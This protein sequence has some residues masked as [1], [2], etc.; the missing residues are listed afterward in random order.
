VR[1]AAAAA[2]TDV[3]VAPAPDHPN[4]D[5]A[6]CLQPTGGGDDDNGGGGRGAI[7]GSSSAGLSPMLAP[8]SPSM[9]VAPRPAPPGTAN[10]QFSCDV[11]NISP[12]LGHRWH[13]TQCVDFDLCHGC[14]VAATPYMFLPPHSPAHPMVPFQCG[15]VPS[16]LHGLR[17]GTRNAH[18]A[19]TTPVS[20]SDATSAATAASARAT[21][22]QTM[23]AS[24]WA[25]DASSTP[26]AQSAAAAV[27]AAV[28]PSAGRRRLAARLAA[29]DD[30]TLG[31]SP[32]H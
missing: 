14:Y 1:H 9:S 12:V 32:Y 18:V 3:L 11:C 19:T 13:C 22:H 25:V 8:P 4:A 15:A 30:D 21:N 31:V 2:F 28:I 23:V 17:A 20:A 29:A 5:Y 10:M 7:A 26:R 24:H 27:A 16:A 6:R